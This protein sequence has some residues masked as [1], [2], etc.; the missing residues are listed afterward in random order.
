M[1]GEGGA[2]PANF[3]GDFT[4]RVA[5]SITRFQPAVYHFHSAGEGKIFLD[6]H[7]HGA[8]NLPLSFK[9]LEFLFRGFKNSMIYLDDVLVG[10]KTWEEVLLSFIVH[11]LREKF[12]KER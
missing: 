8:Q 6:G 7:P 2:F 12:F 5:A 10:S 1:G 11:V 9:P 4:G 3:R